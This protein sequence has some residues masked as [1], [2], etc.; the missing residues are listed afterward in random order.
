MELRPRFFVPEIGACR[1]KRHLSGTCLLPR[2]EVNSL[3]VVVIYLLA[4]ESLR[5]D[6][7]DLFRCSIVMALTVAALPR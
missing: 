3:T 2:G 1:P 5:N 4:F 7:E 6:R